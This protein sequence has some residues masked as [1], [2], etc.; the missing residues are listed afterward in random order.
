MTV[1][2]TKLAIDRRST[3]LEF[4]D[5]ISEAG[6]ACSYLKSLSTMN[7]T[8]SVHPYQ[9][10]RGYQDQVRI[11]MKSCFLFNPPETISIPSA[12]GIDHE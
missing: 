8:A 4:Y 10:G 2:R 6:I 11:I 1:N 7:Q 5:L 3:I 9:F 12:C